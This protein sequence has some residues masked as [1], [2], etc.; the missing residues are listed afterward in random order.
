[1]ESCHNAKGIW[2]YEMKYILLV[3]DD[4]DYLRLFGNFLQQEGFSVKCAASGDEAL[5]ILKD[6]TVHLMITDLNMPN[7]NGIELA[8]KA[9]II[10]PFMPVILHTGDISPEI[11]LLSEV[12]GI[13]RVM[14]KPVNP[15]EMLEAVRIELCEI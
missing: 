13:S 11:S 6:F 12:V 5:S 1:M 4:K 3:D 15:G 9:L 10:M 14:A 7:M 2:C 8:K